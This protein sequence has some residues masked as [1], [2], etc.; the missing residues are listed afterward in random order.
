MSKRDQ[1]V[2]RRILRLLDQ[3]GLSPEVRVLLLRTAFQLSAKD[4][5]G[6]YDRF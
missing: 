4:E 1:R 3:Q 5:R 2:Y 6:R